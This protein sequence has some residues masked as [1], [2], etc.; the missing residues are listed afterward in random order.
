VR[1][2]ATRALCTLLAYGTG[3]DA[4]GR[5]SGISGHTSRLVD[6]LVRAGQCDMDPETRCTYFECLSHLVGRAGDSLSPTD[7][8][9]LMPGL[10]DAWKSQPWDRA[11]DGESDCAVDDPQL[12]IVPFTV[13]L[14]NIATYGKSL[15]APF[16][17]RVFEKACTDIEGDVCVCVSELVVGPF[18]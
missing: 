4:G 16:A 5:S 2:I 18:C 7:M 8:E 3:S 17:E 15:F 9:R 13:A 1:S 11:M 14:T 6:D 10:I 12:T